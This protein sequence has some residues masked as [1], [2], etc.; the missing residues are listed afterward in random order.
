MVKAE[1]NEVTRGSNGRLRVHLS[2]GEDV[3]VRY[4]KLW[5]SLFLN[6]GTALII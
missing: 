1:P 4:V 3:K 6:D 5:S 2:N